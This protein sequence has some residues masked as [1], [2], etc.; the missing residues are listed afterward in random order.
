MPGTVREQHQTRKGDSINPARSRNVAPKQGQVTSFARPQLQRTCACGGAFHGG[1][2]CTGCKEKRLKLRQKSVDSGAPQAVPQLV[3]DVLRSSGQPLSE[4][5]RTVMQSRFGHDFSRIRVHTDARAADSAQ[6]VNAMAYTVGHHVVFGAG[7]YAPTTAAGNYLLAHELTHVVQ[8]GGG[9]APSQLVIGRADN[10]HEREAELTAQSGLVTPS[11]HHGASG[12]KVQRQVAAARAVV[13]ICAES[14]PPP[15]CTICL[16]PP[17]GVSWAKGLAGP[18]IVIGDAPAAK[19]NSA[20]TEDSANKFLREDPDC[21]PR[22][23][24]PTSPPP[25]PATKKWWQLWK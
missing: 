17:G 16:L 11:V 7:Q 18:Y 12:I 15:A 23:I 20:L 14:P 2:E 4:G 3:H 10:T 6:A 24:G 9:E 19:A 5:A 25:M 22:T 1:G 13:P 8:Q 21:F